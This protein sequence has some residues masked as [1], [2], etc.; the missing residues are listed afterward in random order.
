MAMAATQRQ[1]KKPAPE[2]L[3]EVAAAAYI[4]MSVAYLRA[5]RCRGHVGGHTPGPPFYR[6]GAAIRYH[7]DDLDAW[8]AA[9]RVDRAGSSA[10]A[11]PPP[12]AVKALTLQSRA[13][14][15]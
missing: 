8:L 9:H 11:L 1:D 10:P 3:N 13:T 7:R 15:E 4:C 5:D 6:L 14:A 2:L 12:V